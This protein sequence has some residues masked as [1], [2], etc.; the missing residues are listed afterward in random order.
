M[1]HTLVVYLKTLFEG[2]DTKVRIK[3]MG[4]AHIKRTPVIILTNN[5]VNFMGDVTFKER[6][7]QYTWKAAPFLKDYKLKPYP[8]SF[9]EL[10]LKYEIKF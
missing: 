7:K 9:F 1:P 10:L 8:L 6:L 5:P 4:D 2:G 3:M